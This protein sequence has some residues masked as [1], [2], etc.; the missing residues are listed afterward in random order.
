MGGRGGDTAR[1]GEEEEGSEE[2]A[3]EGCLEGGGG[4]LR[5]AE[6]TSSLRFVTMAHAAVVLE[7]ASSASVCQEACGQAVG[8]PQWERRAVPCT[9]PFLASLCSPPLPFPA[10]SWCSLSPPSFHEPPPSLPSAFSLP[11]PPS[12]HPL[13]D[14]PTSTRPPCVSFPSLHNSRILITRPFCFLPLRRPAASDV[15]QFKQRS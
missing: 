4:T 14:L 9:F 2:Q 1:V 13:A 10:F 3:V 6:T 5:E 15:A 11:S 7:A 12:S 8:R